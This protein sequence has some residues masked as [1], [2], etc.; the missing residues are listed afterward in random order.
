MRGSS[1]ARSRGRFITMSLCFRFT[2]LSST[3]NFLPAWT[4]SAL[5]YPVML[6]I[7]GAQGYRR[8]TFNVQCK[9]TKAK[10]VA[11]V[12]PNVPFVLVAGHWIPRFAEPALMWKV[13]AFATTFA[14]NLT[15][16]G[17]AANMIVVESAQIG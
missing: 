3:L 11:G 16:V 15:I 12:F 8:E 9:A 2:E 17:S 4:T 5:P 6:L 7:A 13:L 1:S 14:G 10:V